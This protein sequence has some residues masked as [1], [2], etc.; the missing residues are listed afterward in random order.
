MRAV[1]QRVSEAAVDVRT[2]E[3]V[4]RVGE[5]DRGLMILLGV[6]DGDTDR[7]ASLLAQK[8][9]KLRIFPDEKK[10]MNRSVRDVEGAALVVSQFTLAGDVSGGNRPS[11]IRAAAPQEADRLYQL[12]ADELEAAG[13]PVQTGRFGASMAVSLVNDG[14]VTI[15]LSV[16]P[17]GKVG[18]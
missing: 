13:V 5:I 14:P 11:F 4:A 17:G 16:E 10:P 7:E 18:N 12:F 8:V 1:V 15:I 6:A 2:G 3:D 9:A